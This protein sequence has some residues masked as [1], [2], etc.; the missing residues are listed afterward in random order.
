[1]KSQKAYNLDCIIIVSSIYLYF[2]LSLTP[3]IFIDWDFKLV[4][5]LVQLLS[6]L[7]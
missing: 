6:L 5:D 4:E 1:M 2:K 3:L 7:D